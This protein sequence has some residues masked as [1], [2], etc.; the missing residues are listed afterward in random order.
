MESPEQAHC[1]HDYWLGEV[2]QNL[3]LLLLRTANEM[4]IR[5]DDHDRGTNQMLQNFVFIFGNLLHL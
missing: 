3:S 2:F 1:N 5:L 4:I